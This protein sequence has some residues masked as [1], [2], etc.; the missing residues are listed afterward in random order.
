[1]SKRKKNSRPKKR[2]AR[3]FE[4][5]NPL[6]LPEYLRTSSEIIEKIK[7]DVYA[8]ELYAAVN[9]LR[10]CPPGP[11]LNILDDRPWA[12]PLGDLYF[13]LDENLKEGNYS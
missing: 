10:R 4:K 12:H 6:D 9:I 13:R 11:I 1:M 2:A 7:D 3:I 5:F 8:Q